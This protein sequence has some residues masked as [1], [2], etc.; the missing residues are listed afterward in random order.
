MP[1][2]L[3][4]ELTVV[5]PFFQPHAGKSFLLLCFADNTYTESYINTID[6]TYTE[7][8]IS[9]IGKT[10]KLQI[11][12]WVPLMTL[13]LWSAAVGHYHYVDWSAPVQ[14]NIHCFLL[15]LGALLLWGLFL[16][17]Y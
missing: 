15:V 12:S 14:F 9:I 17:I 1:I 10:I 2:P 5:Q 8:Y 3:I 6:D 4:I 11:V 7:S 13:L 16:T